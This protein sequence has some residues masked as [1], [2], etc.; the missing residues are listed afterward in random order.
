MNETWKPVRVKRHPIRD[1]ILGV[2]D[3]HDRLWLIVKGSFIGAMTDYNWE[4]TGA[5]PNVINLDERFRFAG[6]AYWAIDELKRLGYRVEHV[7]DR[8]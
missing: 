1:E 5:T 3:D 7:E 8:R 6:N 4:I 2:S